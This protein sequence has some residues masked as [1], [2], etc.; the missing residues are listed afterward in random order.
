MLQK[1]SPFVGRWTVSPDAPLVE[2]FTYG[3]LKAIEYVQ[4]LWVVDEVFDYTPV[5][6]IVN[7][8]QHRFA[9]HLFKFLVGTYPPP[10]NDFRVTD[11]QP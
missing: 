7:D 3:G 9:L 1:P 8:G 10:I 4:H 5:L 6:V 11:C 2:V